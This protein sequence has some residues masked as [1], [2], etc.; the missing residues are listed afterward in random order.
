MSKNMGAWVKRNF[1]IAARLFATL[2]EAHAWKQDLETANGGD[3][4]VEKI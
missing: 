3:W 2:E 4:Y 1:P